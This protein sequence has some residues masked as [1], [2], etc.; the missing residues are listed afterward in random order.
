MA[1]SRYTTSAESRVKD[2]PL[3]L[4][5][6]LSRV[7]VTLQNYTFV[8]HTVRTSPPREITVLQPILGAAAQHI[9]HPHST[10]C[11]RCTTNDELGTIFP[12]YEIETQLSTGRGRVP[13]IPTDTADASPDAVMVYFQL[14][15]HLIC[16]TDQ[17]QW[18]C[19]KR[20][21]RKAVN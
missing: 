16:A 10:V 4:W 18:S 3:T 6:G 1:Q 17:S 20:A 2:I 5:S 19:R 14:A 9:T 21:A 15:A 13:V 12:R 7:C 11:H 8:R